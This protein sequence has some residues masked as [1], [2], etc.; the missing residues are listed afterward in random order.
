MQTHEDGS[1][2]L[3]PDEAASVAKVLSLG[4]KLCEDLEAPSASAEE[5]TE[6][7]LLEVIDFLEDLGVSADELTEKL[8]S[9]KRSG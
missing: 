4:R 2:V 5:A 9:R 6:V 3:T 8:D 1:V 7:Q